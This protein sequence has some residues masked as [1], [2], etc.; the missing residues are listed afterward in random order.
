M[1]IFNLSF[2]NGTKSNGHIPSEN[3][4][5][6]KM[7]FQLQASS[8][9]WSDF[10]VSAE[11]INMTFDTV[12]RQLLKM[13]Q[14]TSARDLSILI[15]IDGLQEA[16]SVQPILRMICDL[17]NRSQPFVMIACS[18]TVQI[19]IKDFLKLS[20]QP[21]ITLTP[22]PV[23]APAELEEIIQRIPNYDDLLIA[24]IMVQ[25]MDGHGR[26]LEYLQQTLENSDIAIFKPNAIISTVQ[27]SLKIVYLGWNPLSKQSELI[28]LLSAI[29][30]GHSLY[31]NSTIPGT[32]LTVDAILQIGLFRYDPNQCKLTVAYIWLL[33]MCEQVPMVELQDL[34]NPDYDNLKDKINRGKSASL[35]FE[36]FE[37]FWCNYRAVR[38][39]CCSDGEIVSWRH[40]HSG[41]AFTRDCDFNFV[42]KHL[43]FARAKS[44]FGTKSTDTD[45]IKLYDGINTDSRRS[46]CDKIVMN[47][48]GAPSGDSM[49]VLELVDRSFCVEGH[50][51]K[52]FDFSTLSAGAVQ[53]EYEKAVAP[54]GCFIVISSGK[55]DIDCLKQL[56]GRVAIIND[57]LFVKYFG[58]F[59]GR[60]FFY[61]RHSPTNVNLASVY[62][63]ETCVGIGAALA[64]KIIKNRPF[65]GSEDFEKKIRHFSD[66]IMEQFSFS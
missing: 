39:R 42:N 2:E 18:A 10:S 17:I 4:I 22:P 5:P 54:N 59:A 36:A 9:S 35:S 37:E 34:I 55:V 46:L 29:I 23:L 53:I 43:T 19:P 15:L 38:S 13:N 8:L 56:R 14:V 16:P 52:R 65:S 20:G 62:Q 25:D 47:C 45:E 57:D 58:P 48:A 26:A 60:A 51:C 44:Q 41:A 30:C 11:A 27:S 40:F 28:P 3:I 12:V 31:L 21:Y 50:Q 63:L 7:A 24:R 49:V 66:K 61:R 32:S 33:L 64:A 6:A 1:C